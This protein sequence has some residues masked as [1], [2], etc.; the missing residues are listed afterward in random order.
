MK[1]LFYIEP[2]P[3]REDYQEFQWVADEIATMINH[4]APWRGNGFEGHQI[5]LHGNP[6]VIQSL[7][8][9]RPWMSSL[10]L[11]WQEPDSLR[12]I[13]DWLTPWDDD[14]ILIW[15]QL[16]EGCGEVSEYSSENLRR[17]RERFAFDA[18]VFWGTNGAVRSYCEEEQIHSVSME[19]GF[20][21]PPFSQLRCFRPARRERQIGFALHPYRDHR[22]ACGVTEC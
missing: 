16:M 13:E 2:H 7:L 4:A 19:L 20:M 18:I 22:R 11:D 21:R 8:I 6:R 17:V 3:I 15:K 10:F 12:P 1:I 5:K 14:S 9:D